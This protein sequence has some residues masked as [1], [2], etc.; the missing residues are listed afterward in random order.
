MASKQTIAS[1]LLGLMYLPLAFFLMYLI[2]KH[3]HA[4][5]L[6]WFVWIISIPLALATNILAKL[7]EGKSDD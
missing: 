2:L 5:E 1:I 6:M 3:I 7:A 4:T